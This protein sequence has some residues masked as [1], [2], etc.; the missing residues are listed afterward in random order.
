M[1]GTGTTTQ[2]IES[3]PPKS[4]FI[5]H[6]RELTY[7]KLLV[8]RLGRPDITVTGPEALT[9]EGYYNYHGCKFPAIIV[10]HFVADSFENHQGFV[11]L[12]DLCCTNQ[13]EL[14]S[15]YVGPSTFK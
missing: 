14:P 12:M 13:R 4:L 5:W 15:R 10:D 7:P 6:H 3:A 11:R 2:Q 1:R 8:R 9:Q